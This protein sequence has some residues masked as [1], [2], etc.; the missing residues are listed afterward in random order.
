VQNVSERKVLISSRVLKKVAPEVAAEPEAAAE[1]LRGAGLEVEEIMP[2]ADL[3]RPVIIGRVSAVTPHPNAD[4]L[5]VCQ[6]DVG[7]GEPLQIVTG[8]DNVR[9]GGLYAVIRGGT[10]LPNGTRIRK[11]KLRGERSEGMLGSADELELGD[12]HHGLLEIDGSPTPGTA[13]PDAIPVAGFVI[14]VS[15]VANVEELTKLLVVDDA[16][17]LQIDVFADIACPWCYI[18]EQRLAAVLTD[19]PDL[20]LTWR[21]RPFQ[22]QPGIPP[23]GLPWAEFVATKFG[24]DAAAVFEHTRAVGEESGLDFR[25]DRIARAPN[26]VD[27]H[28]LVLHAQH[29]GRARQTADALFHAYFTE[30]RDIGDSQVLVRVADEVGLDADEVE[31][32]LAGDA[33]RDAVEESQDAATRLGISGVPFYIFNGRVGISGAQDHDTFAR[34]IGLS[35][36]EDG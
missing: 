1:R 8:A 13:L 17:E 35:F 11:G 33:G 26:T 23:A 25:F 22:L 5:R 3:L 28:R 34:A 9:E 29:T 16:A 36:K 31:A 27:A 14:R 6:V 2:L 10:T 32:Y 12:D 19:R 24:A 15:G 30:G 7:P 18:G 20:T 4:R 21:W